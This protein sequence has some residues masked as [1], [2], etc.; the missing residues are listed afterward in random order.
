MLLFLI[1]TFVRF[2]QQNTL[3]KKNYSFLDIPYLLY[4]AKFFLWYCNAEKAVTENKKNMET[5]TEW[6]FFHSIWCLGKVSFVY[7][8][9]Q[10]IV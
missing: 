2:Q 9:T 7:Y 4:L 6:N 5:A 1:F 8:I 3:C 10:T